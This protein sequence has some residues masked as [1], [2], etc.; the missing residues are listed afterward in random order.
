[1]EHIVISLLKVVVVGLTTQFAT[2]EDSR[3]HEIAEDGTH[4]AAVAM[5]VAAVGS[6]VGGAVAGSSSGSIGAGLGLFAGVATV[7]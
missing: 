5:G 6:V 4:V 3:I 2:P 1:M 7:D